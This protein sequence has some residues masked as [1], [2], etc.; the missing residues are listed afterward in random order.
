M[1]ILVRGALIVPMTAGEG[2]VKK[3]FTGSVATS[4]NRIVMVADESGPDYRQRVE[5]WLADN[6][7]A[8]VI[9]GRGKLLMPGLINTHTH[10]AMTLMRNMAD[11]LPLMAWLH[12]R[13]WPFESRLGP[14]QIAAGA[15]LGMAEMMLSGTTTMVDMYWHEAAVARAAR[16]M[17]IRAVLCPSFI[18]GPRMEEFEKDL[19]RTLDVA[20]TCE[21]LAVRVAPHAAYSCSMGN[22]RRAMDLAREHNIGVTIHL[23]ETLDE[24]RIVQRETGLTPTALL[25]GMGLFEIPTI[26]AHCVHVSDEDIEILRAKNVTVAHNPQSNM[27]LASGAAPVARMVEAGVNVTIGTDGSSS[28]NDLDMWDEM[29]SASLLGKLT[30]ANPAVLPAYQIVEMATSRA[31]KGIGMEGE[32]GIVAPGALV[33]L[34]LMDTRKP[35]WQPLHDPVSALVYSAKA[36][37]IHTVVI[38]GAITVNAGQPVG[39]DLDGLM[40]A[41]LRATHG[42]YHSS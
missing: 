16:D 6:P 41:A 34:I 28:N 40:H 15:R 8:R 39:L 10:A 38:N 20:A 29:R 13:V 18:D 11:D 36:S 32:L 33:D 17:G 5:R 4:G 27:K 30:A 23:S 7:D 1:G 21:R 14:E 24:Q 37:D 42:S 22:L 19:D 3:Y 35:H 25:D 12:D 26:A 2:D 31:A 9:D